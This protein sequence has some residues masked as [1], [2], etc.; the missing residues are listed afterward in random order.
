VLEFFLRP[1]FFVSDVF[2]ASVPVLEEK[3]TKGHEKKRFSEGAC[4]CKVS[5]KEGYQH[6]H[7]EIAATEPMPE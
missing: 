3:K 1:S 6:V 2:F 4:M 7:S 5:A